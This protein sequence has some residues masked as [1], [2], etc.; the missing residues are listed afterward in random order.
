MRMQLG[1]LSLAASMVL[2]TMNAVAE[3]YVNIEFM[4]YNENDSRVSVSAPSLEIN[5]DFGADYTLNVDVVLDSVSGASPTYYDADASSGASAYNRGTSSNI[6]YDNVTFEENR[7]AGSA[8]L[9]TRFEN[10]D[11]LNVGVSYSTE[12]DFYSYEG[13]ASY[14]HYLDSSHNQSLSFGG[15]YQ[16]NEILI[17]NCT[18]NS[19]CDAS[20][21]A[22]QKMT[23]DV[24]NLQLAFSQVI[25]ETSV[26]N[27]GVFYTNESG[28]LSS[29][30]HNIVRNT[31]YV[32]AEKKPEERAGYGLKLS[33]QKALSDT[34]YGQLSYKY[35]TDDWDV[36]SHTVDSH[37]YYEIGDSLRLG[38]GLRYYNQSEADFYGE[39]FTTETFA[40]SDYRV[41]SFDAF[42]YKASLDYEITKDLSYNLGANYYDQSTGLSA[43]FF[44]TG[45][46]YKF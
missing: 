13:S 22:S 5:K 46:K 3:D 4:Q 32:E 15:S 36:N 12:S 10:R 7:V 24:Y 11:E 29:P 37:L 18:L 1:K 28:Y 35:Y 8:N 44:T 14:L 19:S 34:L 39:A 33:Y 6:K 31:N 9:T 21:G 30:Y 26:A 40:S 25:D 27:V 2:V 20:S 43:T 16:S 41:S 42:T 45:I 23:N 38:A 17:K